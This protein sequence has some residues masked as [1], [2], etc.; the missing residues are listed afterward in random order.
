MKIL[1]FPLKDLES[2]RDLCAK[3]KG[4][5]Y[6][7]YTFYTQTDIIKEGKAADVEWMSGTWGNRIYRQAGGIKGWSSELNDTSA[8][9]MREQM[10]QHFPEVT[11]DQVSITVY[12][13]TDELAKESKDEI[14]RV[15]LNKEDERV[16][17]YIHERGVQPKLNVQA[18]RTR[19]K[20]LLGNDLFELYV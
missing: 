14:D 15:L 5:K 8:N 6:Y 17:A 13:Y 19:R 16:R 2:P 18:T 4:V 12:D 20:P 10:R 1:T 11:K 3:M 7:T 9:K